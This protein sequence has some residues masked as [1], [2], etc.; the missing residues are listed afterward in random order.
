ML[1][2]PDCKKILVLKTDTGSVIKYCSRCQKDFDGD[3]ERVFSKMK[4]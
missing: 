3:D 2:C 1:F 4:F